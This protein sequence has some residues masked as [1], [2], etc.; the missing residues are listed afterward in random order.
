MVLS[1]SGMKDLQILKHKFGAELEFEFYNET[2]GRRYHY[3]QHPLL[4]CNYFLLLNGKIISYID[5]MD[6]NV[7]LGFLNHWILEPKRTKLAKK[8][9]ILAKKTIYLS[10]IY[11]ERSFRDQHYAKFFLN[12]VCEKL[13]SDFDSI[14]LRRETG[15]GIFRKTE[16]LYFWEAVERLAGLEEVRKIYDQELPSNLKKTDREF[17]VKILR[18]AKSS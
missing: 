9:P 7:Q 12:Q 11:I 3:S 18:C 10:Y 4:S 14:W 17:M 15:S 13:K 8:I 16:F 2:I 6:E 1:L 5:L